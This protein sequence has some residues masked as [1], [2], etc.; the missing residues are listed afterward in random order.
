MARRACNKQALRGIEIEL[1]K[2]RSRNI[3]FKTSVNACQPEGP[4]SVP[5][6]RA[7]IKYIA[8]EIAINRPEIDDCNTILA[9]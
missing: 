1:R 5:D 8:A 2:S 9:G 7:E 3:L 4:R 6:I